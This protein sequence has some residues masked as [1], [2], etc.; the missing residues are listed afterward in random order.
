MPVVEAEPP[1]H[2]ATFSYTLQCSYGPG[3]KP[4]TDATTIFGFN[5]LIRSQVKPMR[6]RAPGAKFSTST[7]HSLINVSKT[8]L[9][10]GFFVSSVIERLLWLSIVKY[11][12]SASGI[13]SEE[14]TSELQSLMRISYAVFCFKKNTNNIITL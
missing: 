4:L 14:H 1:A 12:L 13:R 11:R 3:P 2:C 7:S 8:C 6:S 9:P 5:S 10:L